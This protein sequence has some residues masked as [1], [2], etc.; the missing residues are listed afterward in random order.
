M[1]CR[2]MSSSTSISRCL[3]YFLSH[4]CRAQRRCVELDSYKCR[5]TV[6]PNELDSCEC[7]EVSRIVEQSNNHQ[8][9]NN[10]Q[11]DKWRWM[12]SRT[13]N[14]SDVLWWRS[15]RRLKIVNRHLPLLIYGAVK[16]IESRNGRGNKLLSIE[17]E[18][19]EQSGEC[20][21]FLSLLAYSLI[22]NNKRECIPRLS[23][24]TLFCFTF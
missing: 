14:T 4:S 22:V 8:A 24:N 16:E 23:A 11:L 9:R 10:D 7:Q 19:G 17:Q 12:M 1:T 13:A 21:L 6:A 3:R 18:S 20:S 5:A 15:R 2:R